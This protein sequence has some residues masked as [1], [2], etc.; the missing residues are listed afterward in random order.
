M[1]SRPKSIEYKMRRRIF[2]RLKTLRK[3]IIQPVRVRGQKA[4]RRRRGTR[5]FKLGNS[6]LLL[7][8]SVASLS[9]SPLPD[10]VPGQDFSAR[11]STA[12]AKDNF[13]FYF[14]KQQVFHFQMDCSPNE[15]LTTKFSGN[16]LL[17]TFCERGHLR[18]I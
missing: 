15:D 9:P 3:C 16:C 5:P 10:D 6:E 2:K 1:E 8:R 4:K 13:P 7:I 11:E 18:V 12:D 17:A 14:C